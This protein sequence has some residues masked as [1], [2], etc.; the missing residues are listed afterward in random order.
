MSENNKAVYIDSEIGELESVIIHTPGPE[1]ENLVPSD[2]QRALYSDIL[3]L[4]V[5]KLEYEQ[6]SGVLQKVCKVHQLRDLL[7]DVLQQDRIKEMLINRI[8]MTEKAM[9]IRPSL[10]CI[11]NKELARLFIEGVPQQKDTLTR[12]LDKDS[13]A[14]QPLHN[15]FF[16]RD[17]SVS[18]FGSVLISKMATA[19]RSRE[20]TIMEA[21][22]ENHPDLKSTTLNPLYDAENQH[23]IKIEGGDI[24]IARKDIIIMG[25]GAR[26]SSQG[27]DF[28][29]N[30]IKRKKEKFHFIVQEL[31]H[32][33]ESFIHLDMVFTLIDKNACV[34]YEPLILTHNRYQTVHIE[35]DN[36]NVK[37]IQTVES[38]PEILRKLGMELDIISCGGSVNHVYQEREQW[39]SGANFFAIAPGKIIGYGR[40][41]Y[42][43]E[44]LNQHGFEVISANDLISNKISIKDYQQC[45][46]TI[47]GSELARG[48]GGARCMSMPLKRKEV[49]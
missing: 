20:A 24:V 19:I 14:I 7:C 22:F 28:L 31:P 12:F 23:E 5:A 21:I 26:T 39:H 11:D 41:I 17:A 46:I 40:N 4:Q 25:I 3:N 35:I 34:V 48:G 32:E 42:T 38:L 9:H 43:L 8:C 6:F 2:V 47:E 45:V 49:K 37:S 33:P 29:M 36:G 1:I 10:E 44:A 30:C 18:I 15:A 16:T 13:Y 27:F